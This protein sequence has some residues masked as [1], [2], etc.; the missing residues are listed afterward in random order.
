VPASLA[1]RDNGMHPVLT[2]VR[3]RH[4]RPKISAAWAGHA[5]IICTA[6]PT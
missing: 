1:P 2:H 4:R 6:C 5:L 3:Q